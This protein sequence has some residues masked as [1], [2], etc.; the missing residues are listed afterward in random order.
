MVKSA[1]KAAALSDNVTQWKAMLMT[2]ETNDFNE[3]KINVERIKKIKGIIISEPT[4][5]RC[6]YDAV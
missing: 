4:A 6:Y 5:A 3:P 2:V 1:Q